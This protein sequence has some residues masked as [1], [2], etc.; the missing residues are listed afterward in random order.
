MLKI[1]S[2]THFLTGMAETTL[3]TASKNSGASMVAR[4]QREDHGDGHGSKTESLF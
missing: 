2:V 4:A 3:E 1:E